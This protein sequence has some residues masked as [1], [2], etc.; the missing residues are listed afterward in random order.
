M[1]AR[2]SVWVDKFVVG[3]TG[4]DD[5]GPP[6]VHPVI[7]IVEAMEARYETDAHFT[8]YRLVHASGRELP[9]CPR[10]KVE[11]LPHLADYEVEI[12]FDCA[13]ADIDHADTHAGR[14]PEPPQE[15]RDSMW[16]LAQATCPGCLVYETRSGLRIVVALPAPMGVQ[17]WQA[18]SKRFRKF[19]RDKGLPADEIQAWAQCYRL[20]FVVREGQRQERRALIREPAVLALPQEQ[21]APQQVDA[22]IEI[23]PRQPFRLP[24]RI[25]EGQRHHTLVRYAAQLR[26]QGLDGPALLAQLQEVNRTRCRPAAPDA[27]INEI[28]AWAAAREDGQRARQAAAGREDPDPEDEE[29]DEE[30]FLLGDHTEIAKRVAAHFSIGSPVPLVADLGAIRRYDPECGFYRVI[31][32]HEI[33]K[34]IH[35]YSGMDV[36]TLGPQ[37]NV[38]WRPL[39]INDNTVVGAYKSLHRMLA[40]P[41][42]FASAPAGISFGDCWVRVTTNGIERL[43][44]EPWQKAMTGYSFKWT[45]EDPEVWLA[46]LADYWSHK[47]N[48]ADNVRILCEFL[49]AS[50]CGIA[51][52]FQ[53]CLALVGRGSNGKSSILRVISGV[54]P[55]STV[56]SVS[57]QMFG[58]ET[59]RAMLAGS[60]LN[61]VGELP[62]KRIK[63]EAAASLKALISGDEIVARHLRE[64]PFKF[65]PRAGHI[66]AANALPEVEDDSDGLFRRFVLLMLDKQFGVSG[67]H[68]DLAEE[69]LAVDREKIVCHA[70]RC[71]P[72]LLKRGKY[73]VPKE[74]V[75]EVT[76]WR[77]GQDEIALFL[78]DRTEPCEPIRGNG[79]DGESLYMAYSVWAPQNG[80]EQMN[81][82]R[83]LNM[84][85]KR[86]K[87]FYDNG[88]ARRMYPVTLLR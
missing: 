9:D 54:F 31:E 42:F 32:E 52:Q 59:Y 65:K 82:N 45:D 34:V 7:P 58:V 41:G 15:W 12:R 47:D 80:Y 3:W 16:E 77:N 84:V 79:T 10:L 13:V 20:P 33:S 73:A 74:S 24:R 2:I 56:T 68:S 71:V 85:D 11:T 19:L 18:W 29:G 4:A 43:P 75:D 21:A 88:I 35:S 66:L 25:P 61:V 63:Q 76:A 17:Q 48:H 60:L 67:G 22:G 70:L 55:D 38:I 87:R 26:W 72:E 50:L 69:V 62:E 49:G 51:P 78:A 14:S 40:S 81:K 37:G 44:H 23:D 6:Q 39:R 36:R 83:F 46:M 1:P 57:P 8:P 64:N 30:P 28:A 27:E 53:A 86:R 5:G